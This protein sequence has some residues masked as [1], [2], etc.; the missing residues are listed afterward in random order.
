M[1]EEPKKGRH[2]QREVPEMSERGIWTESYKPQEALKS[3]E[4]RRDVTLEGVSKPSVMEYAPSCLCA[5]K[6]SSSKA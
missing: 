1:G 4:Q 2:G 6:S 3:N 5:S